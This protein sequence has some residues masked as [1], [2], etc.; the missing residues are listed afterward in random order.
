M[1]W[2]IVFGVFIIAYY[3]VL[4][5]TLDAANTARNRADVLE[6]AV[7]RDRAM[8]AS[9][10]RRGGEIDRAVV[11][12][13]LPRHPA[14]PDARPEGLQRAVNM[15]L[16]D[17]GV[18]N[19][20]YSER[21]AP[22]RSDEAVRVVGQ[23]AKLDRFVLDVTFEASPERAMAI[24]AKLEQAE[25]VTSISRVKI[26]KS[27]AGRGRDSDGARTVRVNIAVESWIAGRAAGGSTAEGD[28]L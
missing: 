7:R 28:R 9:A 6:A 25:E 2:L 17:N 19:A 20:T 10:A 1:R 12:Y 14:R 22:I 5:P 26:D 18:S 27:A 4:E 24:L 21:S 13:G 11:T 15:I 16:M 8:L 3:I 23:A